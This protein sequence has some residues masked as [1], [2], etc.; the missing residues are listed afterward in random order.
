VQ[1]CRKDPVAG[2]KARGGVAL[3]G[4]KVRVFGDGILG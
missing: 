2:R 1:L 3:H 4:A